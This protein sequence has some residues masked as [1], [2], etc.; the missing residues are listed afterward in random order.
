MTTLTE[1]HGKQ[2]ALGWFAALGWLT[3][4]PPAPSP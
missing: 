3:T 2:A 1:A 4:H